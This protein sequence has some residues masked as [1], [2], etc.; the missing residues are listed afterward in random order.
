M[1]IL[2]LCYYNLVGCDTLNIQNGS[3]RFLNQ[4]DHIFLFLEKHR[5]VLMLSGNVIQLIDSA[6]ATETNS[7]NDIYAN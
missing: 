4:M 7:L 6:N 5:N 3:E 1:G 2:F